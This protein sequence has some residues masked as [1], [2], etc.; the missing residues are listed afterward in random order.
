[1]SKLWRSIDKGRWSA[2]RAAAILRDGHRCVKCGST[3]KLEV[4]H[5]EPLHTHPHLAYEVSNTQTLCHRCHAAKTKAQREGV[6]A[7]P[8]ATV[9]QWWLS[10]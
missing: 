10:P 1:M 3:E 2:T 4:D 6:L 5:I 8:P 9:N 7:P